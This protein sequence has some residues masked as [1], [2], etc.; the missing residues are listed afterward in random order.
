MGYTLTRYLVFV[1]G[2]FI[3]CVRSSAIGAVEQHHPQGRKEAS[4]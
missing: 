1:C 2:P 4:Y 3:D